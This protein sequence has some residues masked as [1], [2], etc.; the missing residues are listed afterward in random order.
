MSRKPDTR[1]A[2][3]RVVDFADY[4]CITPAKRRAIT[5]ADTRAADRDLHKLRQLEA[6]FAAES[7]DVDYAEL[8]RALDCGGNPC[9]FAADT[10]G[11]RT[12]G[13]CFC[14]TRE[15][16]HSVRRALEIYVRENRRMRAEMAKLRAHVAELAGAINTR[17]A[18]QLKAGF[19]VVCIKCGNKRCPM[20]TDAALPCTNS[21]EP[22]QPGSRYA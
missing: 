14:L 6:L 19:M 21:N 4:L 16:R 3:E 12:Q 20:A 10:G 2:L 13:G 17:H 22:G 7:R 18:E 15:D 9:S 11:V 5:S 8:D 1:P